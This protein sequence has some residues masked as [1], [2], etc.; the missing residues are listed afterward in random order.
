MV[1]IAL[2]CGVFFRFYNLDHKVYWFDE[3]MSSHILSGCT[4][5]EVLRM[6]GN[7]V[8][9]ARELLR[10]QYPAAGKTLGDSIN[11]LFQDDPGQSL[12]YYVIA[13]FWARIWLNFSD[14]MVLILR[15]LSA[16]I[17][18]LAFP[19]A[20]WMSWELFRSHRTSLIALALFSVS[21]FQV[22]YAQEARVYS[23]WVVTTLLSSASL[24]WSLRTSKNAGWVVYSVS[25][26]LGLYIHMSSLL[27][28]AA[29]G[30]YVLVTGGFKI[31]S[32]A[33]KF[34]LSCAVAL[35]AFAP[36][37]VFFTTKIKVF[38][39]TIAWTSAKTSFE[40]LISSW[41]LGISSVFLDVN[42]GAYPPVYITLPLL[43]LLGF[44]LY[45]VFYFYRN[46]PK[47]SRLFILLIMLANILPFLLPD[48]ILGGKRSTVPRYFIPFYLGVQMCVAYF[49]SEKLGGVN[50]K[51]T[52]RWLF[53]F[54]FVLALGVVSC[55]VSSQAEQWW[56][57]YLMEQQPQ[58]ASVV[59][60]S[61]KPLIFTSE[62][63]GNLWPLGY[64]LDEK[65]SILII[66]DGSVPTV[67]GNFTDVFLYDT[68]G[69]S[70][71]RFSGKYDY[72][73]IEG[74]SGLFRLQKK[75]V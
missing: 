36:W 38:Y 32:P 46:A 33:K 48:L 54:V 22:L 8:I 47:H 11:V 56:N 20:Y 2:L 62:S 39:S 61:P 71:E 59:N 7:Q 70:V 73:P 52:K 51:Q 67:A 29:H 50:V 45:C 68:S 53:V 35:L 4:H 31:G 24:L 42:L 64:M 19:L 9:G 26:A 63:L 43:V 41:G 55:A 28:L 34:I 75:P 65:V 6:V 40:S 30:I 18:L 74:T 57:K 25:M 12:P 1:V 3:T 72:S 66:S 58:I 23:L 44:I 10:Y 69:A 16:V 21:P 49:F 60:N 14:N 27:V 15:G 17:S 37:L 13:W 5:W